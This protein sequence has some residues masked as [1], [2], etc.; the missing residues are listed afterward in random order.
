MSESR[1][2]EN[3]AHASMGA[4]RDRRP[5]AEAARRQAPPAYPKGA[6][7]G[8]PPV[9]ARTAGGE[10]QAAAGLG[11]RR[12]RRAR[13]AP[14]ARLRARPQ[15]P[16]AVGSLREGTEE[17]PTLSRLGVTGN[18]ERTLESTNPCESMLEIVRRTERNVTR[19]C[20]GEM[21][22]R[23]TVAGM[24]EA[25]TAVSNDHRLARPGHPRRRH[26]NATTSTAVTPRQLA[27]RPRRP[28]L[29]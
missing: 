7:R 8:P 6:Q 16:G 12:R 18:L 17:T 24:L 13:P 25:E 28:L 15:P 21:A 1:E 19:W 27:P 5:P 10:A 11:G 4:G 26:R 23:W 3:L 22:L 9:S 2:A 14:S 20:P 29:S